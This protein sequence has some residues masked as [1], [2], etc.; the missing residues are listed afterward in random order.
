M[1][2]AISS[3]AKQGISF[4]DVRAQLLSD[5]YTGPLPHYKVTI[6]TMF[7][8]GQN[9]LRR[10]SISLL[11]RDEDLV[12]PF[13]KLVNPLGICFFGKWR[14]TEDLG[15]TGV[16]RAGTEYLV[17]VR[18]SNLMTNTDRG[19]R[20]SF[21]I[22]GKIFP[23]LDPNEVVKPVN[24]VTIDTLTGTFLDRF[25]DTAITNEPGQ[26]LNFGL[27]GM[28][29]VVLN[30][31][32]V[33]SRVDSTP[34]HRPL[35]ALI[36]Q[37]LKPNEIPKGPWWIQFLGAKDIGR[38]DAVDFRDELRL[39]NYK[40]GRLRFDISAAEKTTSGQRPWRRIGEIDLNEEVCSYSGDHRIR[41]H[42]EPNRKEPPS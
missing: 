23:T 24:V 18:C 11:Y 37:G 6:G 8:G 42:H 21:C 19:T 30:S 14:I 4:N 9:L 2:G 35:D 17:V 33:F 22:A 38:S 5:P 34:T 40:D 27:L 16:F 32:W 12:P 15:Y 41:F 31:V 3:P 13:Q 28:L 36:A 10:D 7:K 29:L 20:R 1:V 39:K 26:P 25:T